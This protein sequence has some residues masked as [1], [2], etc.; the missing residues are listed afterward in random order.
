[1]SDSNVIRPKSSSSEDE[2]YKQWIKYR[3]LE[4]VYNRDKQPNRL[5]SS[6]NSFQTTL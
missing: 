5:D 2:Y 3:I 1:M 4:E 6:D